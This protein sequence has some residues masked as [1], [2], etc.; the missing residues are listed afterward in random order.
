MAQPETSSTFPR[1]GGS[2]SISPGADFLTDGYIPYTFTPQAA[3][4]Y[5]TLLFKA[6]PSNIQ[7]F[8]HGGAF[9]V[10]NQPTNW[11]LPPLNFNGQ[12]AWILDYHI[13]PGGSV[14]PQQLWFPQGQGD[15]RCYIEQAHL[16]L[17]M[18]FVTVDGNLGV[19]VGNA[20]AGQMN[21]RGAGDPAPFGDK[22]TTKIRIG[23]CALAPSMCVP[24]TY[25][26]GRS[27]RDIRPPNTRSN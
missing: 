5:L 2:G 20:A 27:G 9:L 6:N 16:Q 26:S 8:F 24:V 7:T 19:P 11:T 4:H 18:F 12:R 15:W 23:V 10:L 3:A 17:P 21:L 13:R 25:R 14:V 22:T 1:S